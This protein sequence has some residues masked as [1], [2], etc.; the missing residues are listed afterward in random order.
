M[1]RSKF[2]QRTR[3]H[4]ARGIGAILRNAREQRS[5]TVAE[6]ARR[7]DVSREQIYRM[8]R[9]ENTTVASLFAYANQV[10]IS[11][12]LQ[13]EDARLFALESDRRTKE[14]VTREVLPQEGL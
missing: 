6:M 3:V 8:E 4:N 11:I 7:V 2:R 5:I 14:S 10:S 13:K 9:G 1:A 12:H